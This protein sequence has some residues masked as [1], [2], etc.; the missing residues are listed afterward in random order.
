MP[1]ICESPPRNFTLEFVRRVGGTKQLH[2]H[3][4]EDIDDDG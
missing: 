1:E 2:A 3:H 4:G